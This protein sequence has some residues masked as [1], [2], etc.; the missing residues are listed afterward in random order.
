MQNPPSPLLHPTSDSGITQTA[1][2]GV[3]LPEFEPNP[4]SSVTEN[5]W[6]EN[7]GAPAVATVYAGNTPNPKSFFYGFW[8]HGC[9]APWHVEQPRRITY[10]NEDRFRSSPVFV[11]RSEEEQALQARGLNR[12]KAIGLP[13]V[14]APRLEQPRIGNSLLIVPTHTLAGMSLPDRSAYRRYVDEV[15]QFFSDFTCVAVCIHPA[16]WENGLWLDEFRN[17]NIKIIKGADHRDLNALCRMRSLF[18]S[19]ECVTTN[20]WGS[21]VAYALAEGARVSIFGTKPIITLEQMQA[22]DA[23]WRKN[24]DGRKQLELQSEQD[25]EKEYLHHYMRLPKDGVQNIEQGRWLIGHDNKVSRLE[26]RELLK[27]AYR[28]TL[29]QRISSYGKKFEY[30]SKH[31]LRGIWRKFQSTKT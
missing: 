14:Y 30:R 27:E 28:G 18:S 23:T 4:Q 15:K 26:M 8:Q 3:L 29:K 12:A 9:T 22:A 17:C 24:A 2:D 16:C 11:A 1:A 20:G 13:I 31:F 10:D 5:A 6:S 7:Y 25:A 19:F 21:H